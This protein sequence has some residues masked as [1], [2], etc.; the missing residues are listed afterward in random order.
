MRPRQDKSIQVPSQKYNKS[1]ATK[2]NTGTILRITKKKL[3]DDEFAH[4]HFWQ[5]KGKF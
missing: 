5:M 3:Q 4:F 1:F 2:N